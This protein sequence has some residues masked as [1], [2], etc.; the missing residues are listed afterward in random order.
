[1]NRGGIWG[2]VMVRGLI[3]HRQNEIIEFAILGEE[4][5]GVGSEELGLLEGRLWLS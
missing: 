5:E 3:G 1:M 2:D 4:E